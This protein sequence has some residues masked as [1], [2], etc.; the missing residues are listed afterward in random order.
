MR[1]TCQN[2]HPWTEE[3]V[4]WRRH[5]DG[6]RRYRTCKIC[7]RANWRRYK[8]LN[9]VQVNLYDLESV[10]HYLQR[11]SLLYY[12]AAITND[13]K[14]R[15]ERINEAKGEWDKAVD[16]MCPVEAA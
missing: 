4:Y 16:I 12:A 14:M 6:G 15:R 9:K 13:E 5:T 8:A 11:A 2:G 10:S 7:M 1:E 3:N